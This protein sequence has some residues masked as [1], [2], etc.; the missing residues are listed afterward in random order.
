[1]VNVR[2][3][4]VLALYVAA[5]SFA[6]D[7]I[8]VS[9]SL[10]EERVL[11]G[12]AVTLEINVVSQS[13]EAIEISLPRLEGLTEL[14]RSKSEG[15]SIQWTGAGQ[16]VTREYTVTI[17]LQADKAGKL[18][19]PPITARAGKNRGSSSELELSVGASEELNQTASTP[20]PDRIAPPERGEE[21]LFMRYKVDKATAYVGEQIILDLD[22]Y[23]LPSMN[24]SID[25]AP[26]LPALDGFWKETLDQ[27]RQLTRRIESI[28]GK[29]YHA[30]RVW[31]I[32]IFPLDAGEKTIAQASATF[33]VNRSIFGGGQR[34]RRKAP[35]IKLEILPLPS[36]GRPGN[37]SAQ[38]VGVYTLEA[39]LDNEKVPAGKALVLSLTLN[40]RGNLKSVRL[41]DLSEVP[42][43]RVF[44]P[45]V[46]DA[47]EIDGTGIHGSKRAE[48]LLMPERGGRLEVPSVEMTIFNPVEKRYQRLETGSKR[49]VVEGEPSN[50]NGETFAATQT[51]DN[52]TRL[53]PVKKPSLRPL[54]Y[55]SQLTAAP[56]PP[57]KNPV[58]VGLFFLPPV[59][60]VAARILSSMLAL[61]RR[62]T[63]GSRRRAKTKQ[64]RERLSKARKAVD[65]GDTAN[66]YREMREALLDFAS[67]QSGVSLR[68]MTIEEARAAL[69]A[70]G[71]KESLLSGYV[72][73]MEAADYA[74]FAPQA[75]DRGA[76]EGAADRWETLFTELETFT[77]REVSR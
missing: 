32:A 58:F 26:Q 77:P 5:P 61:S 59:L 68:G 55:R 42:G 11:T 8:S 51:P 39:K 36:E 47:I 43:F 38:N 70:L 10:S 37:F 69:A 1:L 12:D 24:F 19:I 2:A 21:R 62:E 53:E 9:A 14:S 28:Q 63:E 22:V 29:S 49:V 45:T 16:R 20:E 50:T 6:D 23:A 72:R 30:Y 25:D 17:E 56:I 18:T 65:A 27:P 73:E 4:A 71:A 44:P 41:P 13:Q 54:R 7:V 34:E 35:A 33:G 64:A 40:G 75:L 48:I 57:W 31:R 76:L 66:A 46:T 74:A 52:E 67:E 15:T 60:F 3:I